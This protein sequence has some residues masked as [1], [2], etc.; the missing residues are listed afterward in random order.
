MNIKKILFIILT[1]VILGG[2]GFLGY[3][4]FFKSEQVSREVT[5]T[6][7]GLWES[8]TVMQ[9]VIAQW[10]KEHPNIKIDYKK[11]D[12]EDYLARLQS[13]LSQEGGPDVF[14]YHQTWLP[15]LEESLAPVPGPTSKQI[16]LEEN[17]FTSVIEPI[18]KNGQYYGVP[19]MLDNLAL[20]YNQDILASANEQPPI[21]WW[22]LEKLAQDLTVRIDEEKISVAGAA[23]GTT[24]NVDHWSDIIGLMIHQNG[25]EPSQPDELVTDVLKYYLKFANQIKVWDETMPNSTLAFAQEKTAFYFGPS[26]RAFNIQE[27]NPKLNYKI[28]TVPQLPKLPDTD[29]EEAEK[30]EAELTDVHW[31]SFWVE[32]VSNQSKY[33]QE[34]WEFL[35]YLSSK[36][37]LQKMYTAQEQTRPFGEIY[38]RKD[39]A[40]KLQSNPQLKP[41]VDQADTAK[42]WYLASFTHGGGINEQMIKYYSDALNALTTNTNEEEVMTTLDNGVQQVLQR[43]GV[44][45]RD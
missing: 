37:T 1:L 32:G 11:Q 27:A 9:G 31:A 34:A 19:L 24:S 43:Y 29:W 25:G 12:K 10:A 5:L 3:R 38:P 16:G 6:Y 13:A 41:F 14:R 42:T 20:Y 21:T 44:S 36:E 8:E 23:L 30:G 7:W 28:T 17:Y 4:F 33:Q 39:L 15:M 35:E 22:G 18:K 45:T 40:Q 2:A 26:W